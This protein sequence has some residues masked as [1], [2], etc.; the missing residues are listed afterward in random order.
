MALLRFFF[1]FQGSILFRQDASIGLSAKCVLSHPHVC[2]GSEMSFSGQEP[3]E[4]LHNMGYGP[5]ENLKT[6]YAAGI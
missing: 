2:F 6:L 5:T 4:E 3:S 1:F